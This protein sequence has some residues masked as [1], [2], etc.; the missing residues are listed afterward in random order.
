MKSG[1]TEGLFYFRHNPNGS[2]DLICPKCLL[3]VATAQNESALSQVKHG[4]VCLRTS[5]YS[6]RD[7]LTGKSAPWESL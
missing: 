5:N 3:P 6:W 2:W 1:R 7:L 4:H